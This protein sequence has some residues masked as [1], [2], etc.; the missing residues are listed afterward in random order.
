MYNIIF[1]LL[2][3]L[4]VF[5]G[6]SSYFSNSLIESAHQLIFQGFFP[7]DSRITVFSENSAG[8]RDVVGVIE[9]QGKAPHVDQRFIVNLEGKPIDKLGFEVSAQKLTG[10][11]DSIHLH[12]IKI[13][14]SFTED[15][16]LSHTEI[17]RFFLSDQFAGDEINRLDFSTIDGKISMVSRELS[18]PP[19]TVFTEVLPLFLAVV[20]FLLLVKARV[21]KLSAIQDMAAG[22]LMTQPAQFDA[23]NGI[24]GLS[25]LLVLFSH[26][27]PGFA[28]I[29]MG[30][31]LLFVM[32]GFLLTKPFVLASDRIFCAHTI[33]AFVVKRAKRILPMYYFTVFVVY[34]VGFE[35][36][37]AARHFLFIE[38][39]GHLWAIPQILA[40]YLLL[41]GILLI[42]SL[43]HKFHRTA[44]VAFLVTLI[45]IW[46]HYGLF[47]NLFYNG[48]YHTPF[49]LDAFLLGVTASYVQYGLIHPSKRVQ[50]ILA[51]R[52]AWV[53][54]TALIFTILCL[55]WSAPVDPPAAIAHLMDRFDVKCLLAA[56]I[57]LFAVNTPQT[58]YA[59]VIGNPVF[60]SIGIIGF[61]FYLLQ[62]LGIDIVLQFQQNVLGHEELIFRSWGLTFSVLA[63]TYVISLFT[64]SYI[65]RPFF[66]K[67][68]VKQ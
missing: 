64:Y 27:A 21:S 52:S 65:E 3:S 36:D 11:N 23:I 67:I 54:I 12:F 34:L 32:S 1:A 13:V 5:L 14:N 58:L 18:N 15:L 10:P 38:A 35:F 7:L 61:S 19:N 16:F 62:G 29:K 66:G 57:I 2:V 46:K 53:S 9:V 48:S 47:P 6:S 42:T 55:A 20:A 50:S 39:R 17:R 31:A 68:L 25:A 28:S 8:E 30:L 44:S 26:T 24:R 22:R 41:P 43:I 49:M 45:L 60:R 37:T 4:A 40:F 56:I 51:A 63:L 59:R 33:H